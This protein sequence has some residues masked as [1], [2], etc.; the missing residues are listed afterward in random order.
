MEYLKRIVANLREEGKI[1]EQHFFKKNN[2]KCQKINF[3][4]IFSKILFCEFFKKQIESDFH[5]IVV[6]TFNKKIRTYRQITKK[7]TNYILIP[8]KKAKKLIKYTFIKN[9]KHKRTRMN[10]IKRASPFLE[11]HLLERT[12]SWV[13]Q[14]WLPVPL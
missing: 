5:V 13:E 10:L 11:Y 2:Q 7:N 4:K 3:I 1:N 8:E 9:R 12:S 14:W 6:R